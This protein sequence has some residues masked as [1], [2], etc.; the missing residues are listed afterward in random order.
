MGIPISTTHA[1]ASSI[2]G[3]GVASSQGVN[4]RV[5]VKM[6]ASWVITI[7][8]T[9]VVGWVMFQLTQ[10][11]GAAAWIAVG[12]VLFVLLGWIAWA[13]ARAM[14]ADDVAAEL[15]TEEELREPVSAIPAIQGSGALD[16]S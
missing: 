1:A 10:L 2:T 14:H 5:V 15:P 6:V 11:P 12:S 13:M 4:L 3:S 8:S 7:P 9:V 16:P